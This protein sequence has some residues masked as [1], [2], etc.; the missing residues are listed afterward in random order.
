M[1]SQN[2]KGSFIGIT[3]I[4]LANI[5]LDKAT[6]V[7][8][9]E[10]AKGNPTPICRIVG[11]AVNMKVGST[12]KGDYVTFIGLFA[13]N[14][15]IE[16]GQ[17]YRSGKLILPN[18]C[19]GNLEGLLGSA[20]ANSKEG[21]GA[22]VVFGY[23]IICKGEPSAATGYVFSMKSLV[24]GEDPLVDVIAKLPPMPVAK[25]LPKA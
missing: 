24:Q 13:A 8:I 11:Q 22:A 25:L 17:E 6:I 1:T 10:K 19:S 14:N 16:G 4:T 23:E 7:K 12:E 2:N 15:Y 3:K 5:G 21:E 9:V 20:Q 18:V